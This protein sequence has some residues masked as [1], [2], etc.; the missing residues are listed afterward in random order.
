MS[1]IR[2]STVSD[3]AGTGPVTLTKQSAARAWG[4]FYGTGTVSLRESI[5][6]SS[7]VDNGTGDYSFA[8]TNAFASATYSQLLTGSNLNGSGWGFLTIK[9]A[10]TIPSTT[11]YR[12]QGLGAPNVGF[13]DMG[14]SSMATFGDLA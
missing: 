1:E 14:S 13:T 9:D 3:L 2:T 4:N 12:T 5:N 6:I 7:I 10:T 11:G 8:F